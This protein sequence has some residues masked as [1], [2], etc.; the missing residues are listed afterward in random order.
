LY[1]VHLTEEQREELQRRTRIPG[2]MPRTRDRLEMVRLA[3]AG[4]RVPQISDLLRVSPRRVRFW[5]QRFLTGGFDALPDQPHVG[6]QSQLTPEL[7]AAL[8]SEIA[9]GERT[10]TAAQ[11]VEWLAAAH[12]LRLGRNQLGML[13]RRA[14]LAYRRTERSLKHK[15]DPA[16]VAQRQAE[17]Q[18]LEKGGPM[19]AWTWRT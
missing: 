5:L 16:Q 12:G 14:R 18:E 15:Q 8:K 3:D 17:L 10:W 19:G 11:L 2:I 1:R 9:K 6:Q 13:L 7:L 4:W